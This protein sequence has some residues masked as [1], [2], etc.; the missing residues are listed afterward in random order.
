MLIRVKTPRL[1]LQLAGET[2]GEHLDWQ[3]SFDDQGMLAQ[4]FDAQAQLR[5]FVVSEGRLQNAF[6]LLRQLPG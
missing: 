5:G 4:A 3:L 1:P 6:A 2:S